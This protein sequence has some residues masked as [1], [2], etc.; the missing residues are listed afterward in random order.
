MHGF[1]SGR[2]GRPALN[3]RTNE[4]ERSAMSRARTRPRSLAALVGAV[5]VFALVAVAITA[6]PAAAADQPGVVFA[7]TNGAAGNAVAVFGRAADGT[8]TA[9]GSVSTGGLGTGGGLGNQG[10]L[11]LSEDG[12]RLYAVNAG[13]NSVSAFSVASGSL[14]L[15]GAVPSGGVLP[16]SVAVFGSLVYVLNAGG[17]AAPGSIS[18]FTADASGT[19]SPLAGSTRPLSAASVGPAQIGFS[20]DGSALVV[21]EKATSIVDTY[22]V[23]VNGLAAGPVAH[24]SSGATPFGFAFDKRGTLIVSE[25]GGAASALSSYDLTGGFATLSPSVAAP[26]Q[27]AS[28]WVVTTKNGRYAYTTNTG[29]GTISA[30]AIGQDG[31]LALLSAVA[32]TTG[33][34]PVDAALSVN[35]HLLYVLNDSTHRIDAFRVEADGS[36]TSLPAAGVAGLP[37][38]A[39][40]IV[41]F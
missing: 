26:G 33:G 12:S 24:A 21:T 29:S 1:S 20:P 40:G 14:T 5:V 25:A 9:A 3:R 7:L 19:L 31:S 36:L 8:L 17:A 30:Y 2:L 23:G 34:A 18:G 13:S 4:E 10:A 15:L 27:K 39:T 35:S 6:S 16:V 38:G 28:C 41:A 22:A 37:A 11:A 32:G